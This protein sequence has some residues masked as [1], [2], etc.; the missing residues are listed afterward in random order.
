MQD[1][2]FLQA[3][4]KRAVDMPRWVEGALD[5]RDR[6]LAEERQQKLLQD[7]SAPVSV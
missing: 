3:D 2:P 5:F 6:K 1:H 7:T 4:R